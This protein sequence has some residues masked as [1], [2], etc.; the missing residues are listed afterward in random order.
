MAKVTNTVEK[1]KKPKIKR[2]GIHSK[3]KSSK[4]KGSKLYVK[5]YKG[6]GK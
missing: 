1:L 4:L 3:A 2:P 6:Q 5:A